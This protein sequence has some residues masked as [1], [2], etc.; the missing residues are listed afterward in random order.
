[1]K[2]E[3][4]T[5]FAALLVLASCDDTKSSSTYYET[6]EPIVTTS[7]QI[8]A[9][10]S[11]YGQLMTPYGLAI[12]PQCGGLGTVTVSSGSNVSFGSSTT[13]IVQTTASCDACDCS[14]YK[15]IKHDAGTYEGDCS[16]SDGWGH[17][18]G[19]SPS[20]HGLRQY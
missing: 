4:S 20:H 3:L 5:L 7:T 16:H 11:G 10:C 19:H 18:C 13:R 8:C 1:M 15:G 9:R 2:L 14:G 17:S 6:S 12:C